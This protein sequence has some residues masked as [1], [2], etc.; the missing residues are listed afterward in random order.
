MASELRNTLLADITSAMKAQEKEKLLALRT[1][2]AEIKNLAIE[3]RKEELEDSDVASVVAKAI[4]Q[5]EDSIEQFTAAG[6]EDLA[7]KEQAQIDLYRNYQPRQLDS[8]EIEQIAAQAI[9]ETQAAGKKD[10][11]KVM[12]VVMPRVRGKADGKVVNRIVAGKLDA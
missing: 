6:R 7:A 12:K 9:E 11:G 8:A 10:M 4:K 3:Q 1:L 2:N 5:R